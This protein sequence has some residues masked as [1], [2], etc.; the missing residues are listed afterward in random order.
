MNMH[1]M[2]VNEAFFIWKNNQVKRR[3]YI[4]SGRLLGEIH[5]RKNSQ[6]LLSSAQPLKFNCE[7]AEKFPMQLCVHEYFIHQT[8][9]KYRNDII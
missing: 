9:H 2:N 8:I 6:R 7:V 5:A 1:Q 3:I 4:T